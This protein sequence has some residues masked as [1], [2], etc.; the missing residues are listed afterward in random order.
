MTR[1]DTLTTRVVLLLWLTSRTLMSS[2]SAKYSAPQTPNVCLSQNPLILVLQANQVK[3]YPTA[4][5]NTGQICTT[6]W[7]QHQTCC[8]SVSLIEYAEKDIKQLEDSVSKV[9]KDVVK[10]NKA[11][12]ENK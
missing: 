4:Q 9:K 11:L 10:L 2:S 5:P 3:V 1:K 12:E 8:D 6:E 7:T